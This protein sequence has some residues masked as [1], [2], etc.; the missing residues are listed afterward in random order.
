MVTRIFVGFFVRI[1]FI[2]MVLS[3]LSVN[4]NMNDLERKDSPGLRS[5]TRCRRELESTHGKRSVPPNW[6]KLWRVVAP[7]TGFAVL[8]YFCV[9]RE[10]VAHDSRGQQSDHGWIRNSDLQARVPTKG[11]CQL[12]G[13]SLGAGGLWA[14]NRACMG[15]RKH[16]AARRVAGLGWLRGWVS[17]R[18]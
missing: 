1:D 13:N 2:F 18:W 5:I 14:K 3:A 7:Q 4:R 15:R 12:R 11:G 8:T 17:W 9:M 16:G 10:F 6:A